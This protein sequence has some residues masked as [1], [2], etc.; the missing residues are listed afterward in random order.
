[1][2][3]LWHFSLPL[4]TSVAPWKVAICL[5][6]VESMTQGLM[7]WPRTPKKPRPRP[8]PRTA[9]SRTDL[10]E[11]KDR[12]A[13]GQGQG[14]KMQ[15]QVLSKKKKKTEKKRSSQKFF[16]RSPEKNVFLTIFQTLHKILTIHKI[17]L[18][19]NQGQADFRELE[20]LRP[21]PRTSKCV[22]EEV[23]EAKDVLE[24]STCDAWVL[25][26]YSMLPPPGRYSVDRSKQC[27]IGNVI[28]ISIKAI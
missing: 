19:S 16:R 3:H 5:A 15:A 18:S 25:S 23:F 21:R 2:S 22:L 9:L 26:S 1:M 13:R 20:A 27:N 28:L 17:V 8:R 7:P 4:S 14:P 12:N 11:A 10:L 6:D 24:N